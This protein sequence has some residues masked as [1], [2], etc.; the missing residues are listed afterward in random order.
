MYMTAAINY[1]KVKPCAEH[2]TLRQPSSLVQKSEEQGNRK[3]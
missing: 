3:Q 1:S 2:G